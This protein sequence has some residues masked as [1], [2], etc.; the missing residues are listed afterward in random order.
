[1][2]GQDQGKPFEK[3]SK[4]VEISSCSSVERLPPEIGTGF[5]GGLLASFFLG[6]LFFVDF[7]TGTFSVVAMVVLLSQSV[8]GWLFA[9][10]FRL[11]YLPKKKQ[12]P[13]EAAAQGRHLWG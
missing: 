5:A 9:Q 13:E 8:D 7:F 12:P 6:A 2:L 10:A 11:D 3:R 1:M 4:I